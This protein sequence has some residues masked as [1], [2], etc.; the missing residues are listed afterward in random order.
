MVFP[1]AW[2]P[3]CPLDWR[4]TPKRV[5]LEKKIIEGKY[6]FA[7]WNKPVRVYNT[8]ADTV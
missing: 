1:L 4:R 2:C 5:S 3:L 6:W 8:D 7:K